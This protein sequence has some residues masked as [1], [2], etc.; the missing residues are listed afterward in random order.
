MPYEITQCCLPP[1]RGD[2]PALTPAKAVLDCM[3]SLVIDWQLLRGDRQKACRHLLRDYYQSLC[4]HLLQ[5]CK[6]LRG[7]EKHNRRIL[8][9]GTTSTVLVIPHLTRAHAFDGPCSGIT[10]V[11]KGGSIAEWLVCWTQAQKGLGSNHSREAV[12]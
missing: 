10:R 9:V 1:G 8:Q 12:G 7:V 2:I 5:D 11:T 4:K 6:E 3:M